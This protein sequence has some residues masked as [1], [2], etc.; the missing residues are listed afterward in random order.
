V[1]RL[2]GFEF[3]TGWMLKGASN[4]LGPD[5]P[6]LE[7][8][9]PRPGDADTNR[10]ESVE[11][12]SARRLWHISPDMRPLPL[13]PETGELP[14]EF[15]PQKREVPI[16]PFL[17]KFSPT[18]T[19]WVSPKYAGFGNLEFITKAVE[20]DDAGRREIGEIVREIQ[21]VVEWIGNTEPADAV[22]LYEILPNLKSVEFGP[23]LKSVEF[24]PHLRDPEK[25]RNVVI[26][27]RDIPLDDLTASMQMTA[28]VKLDQVPI[29]MEELAG[30]PPTGRR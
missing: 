29:L 20:E 6:V 2:I 13:D 3:E 11:E 5:D 7:G 24:G 15:K 30:D 27:R 22:P 28:G 25:Q 26:D 8:L 23:H 10:K 14:D 19:E 4:T 9:A 17:G 18:R 16:V 21:H 1:Q 12:R